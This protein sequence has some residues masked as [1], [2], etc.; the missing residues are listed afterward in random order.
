MPLN[1]KSVHRTVNSLIDLESRLTI[2][3]EKSLLDDF[4]LF[5][6]WREELTEMRNRKTQHEE[7]AA[8]ET[9]LKLNKHEKSILEIDRMIH[10]E[11]VTMKQLYLRFRLDINALSSKEKE[12]INILRNLLLHQN[13]DN[14]KMDEFTRDMKKVE[15]MLKDVRRKYIIKLLGYF[16][17][18]DEAKEM[19]LE[20]YEEEE[21]ETIDYIIR[22][23]RLAHERDDPN[24]YCVDLNGEV[25]YRRLLKFLIKGRREEMKEQEIKKKLLAKRREEKHRINEE[26]RMKTINKLYQQKQFMGQAST[27]S[28]FQLVRQQSVHSHPSLPKTRRNK[29]GN[30]KKRRKSKRRLSAKDNHHSISRSLSHSR[31]EQTKITSMGGS[32]GAQTGSNITLQLYDDEYDYFY[33]EDE[34]AKNKVEE[35][36]EEKDRGDEIKSGDDDN[37]SYRYTVSEAEELIKKQV[38][39]EEVRKILVNITNDYSH[40]KKTHKTGEEDG[41]EDDLDEEQLKAK[42][43]ARIMEVLGD[44]PVKLED[45]IIN[46]WN[47]SIIEPDITSGEEYLTDKAYLF[48]MKF[49]EFY[50]RIRTHIPQTFENNRVEF[51]RRFN[52]S[53]PRIQN[54]IEEIDAV[55]TVK[56][57]LS[58]EHMRELLH[59]PVSRGLD[60]KELFDCIDYLKHQTDKT[61]EDYL[62][63]LYEIIMKPKTYLDF[64]SFPLKSERKGNK[65]WFNAE[66]K[67]ASG[68]SGIFK[69]YLQKLS[70]GRMKNVAKK[71]RKNLSEEK[72]VKK[73]EEKNK[74]I[75]IRNSCFAIG[76][77]E[78]MKAI[79]KNENLL[80]VFAD[81]QYVASNM[82]RTRNDILCT[83]LKNSLVT[84]PEN[85]KF[86]LVMSLSTTLVHHLNLPKNI[87]F[88]GIR[89]PNEN[90][91]IYPIFKNFIFSLNRLTSESFYFDQLSFMNEKPNDIT[92]ETPS[93]KSERLVKKSTRSSRKKKQL[94]ELLNVSLTDNSIITMTPKRSMKKI[95]KRF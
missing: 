77:N 7:L 92:L 69:E 9:R 63:T 21:E 70:C 95:K 89:I 58:Y 90:F 80:M 72:I 52:I 33:E 41:D 66:S 53:T 45:N 40:G 43:R 12:R 75:F 59:I 1:A 57:S 47:N 51:K 15:E 68:V 34:E 56:S 85:V 82:D 86:H 4:P 16:E 2:R 48:R 28:F 13:E 87:R 62:I 24:I 39:R 14:I 76:Y 42:E 31:R 79:E 29:K 81:L 74:R 10:N 30:S 73:K 26:R 71:I 20:D 6:N 22:C 61:T 18:D 88:I 27:A 37:K 91:E 23:V 84:S 3:S 60:E 94:T 35:K 93:P 36:I 65:E 64:V 49:Y 46:F 17:L 11:K 38:K 25:R 78:T 67:T 19:W 8:E 5:S 50:E 44:I 55:R 83:M 54:E 32:G